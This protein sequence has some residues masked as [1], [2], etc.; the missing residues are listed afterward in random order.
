MIPDLP[1]LRFLALENVI[2]HEFHDNQRTP[3]LIERIRETGLFR[4]PPIVAPLVDGTER[5]M[6]LD[7]ANRITALREM[8]FPDVLV[9]IVNHDDPGL[10]LENW[11]HVLWGMDPKDLLRQVRSIAEINLLSS[12]G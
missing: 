8:G 12:R 11:N 7:G 1:H 5:F 4:N 10:K 3:P 9:Q 6:V 2:I